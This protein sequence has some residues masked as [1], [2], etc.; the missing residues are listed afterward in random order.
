MKTFKW[1]VEFS[2]SENWVEDGFNLTEETAKEMLSNFLP[3]AYGHELQATVKKAPNQDQ[4]L[5][6]QG[7]KS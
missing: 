2:V 5:K 4:I 6:V 7:F 1:T 3:F